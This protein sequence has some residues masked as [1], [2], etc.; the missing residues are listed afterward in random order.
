MSSSARIEELKSIVTRGYMDEKA[1]YEREKSYTRSAFNSGG[2]DEERYKALRRESQQRG[3]STRAAIE[4]AEQELVGYGI[5]TV[6]KSDGSMG[7]KR[8]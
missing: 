6:A 3:A 2:S 8:D 7:F 5:Y 1:A 4:Q